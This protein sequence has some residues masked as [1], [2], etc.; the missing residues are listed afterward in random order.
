MIAICLAPVYIL[1][2]YYIVCRSLKWLRYCSGF[3]A[4]RWVKITYI[5]IY[6][7]LSTS[8]ITA[9]FFPHRWLKAISNQFLGTFLYIL[10]FVAVADLIKIILRKFRKLPSAAG[11]PEKYRKYFAYSGGILTVL[12]LT[13]SVY[14]VLNAKHIKINEYEVSVDK[15]CGDLDSLNV[16]LVADLHLGYNIGCSMMQDMVEKINAQNPDVVVIAGDIYDNQYEALEDPEELA[17][18]LSGIDSTYG[19][20][21]CYGNHDIEEP[22]LAGF[23][24]GSKDKKLNDPRLD[25][26]LADCNIQLLT[27]ETVLVDDSFYIAGRRDHERPGNETESRLSPEALLGDL[28]QTKPIIVIDHEPKELQ[29][30]ATA[31]ADLD[32]CGHTHDGQ[33]WPGNWTI[34]LFWENAC[35][36]L[37]KDQ[38]HNIVTSGV[39]LFGPNMR[40]FTDSEICTIKVNFNK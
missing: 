5:V 8:L 29:E 10:L 9:F 24:F 28:D 17:Q 36:Y 32:L 13:I 34:G 30:L 12:V 31:G 15:T 35:G 23:T 11:E 20:Y 26:F 38:M 27:D 4:K 22:I 21:A 37:Q 1:L 19:V 6:I 18:I 33:V 7:L 39:G 2:N 40:T 3:F 14:G 16:I 25:D